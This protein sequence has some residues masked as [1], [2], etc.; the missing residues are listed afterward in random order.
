M[1][2]VG[3]VSDDGEHGTLRRRVGTELDELRRHEVRT[4]G[5]YA[6]T[7]TVGS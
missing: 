1:Y 4:V 7:P 5:R 6:G 2:Y 3:G